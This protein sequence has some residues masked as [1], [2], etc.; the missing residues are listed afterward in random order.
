[1]KKGKIIAIVGGKGGVG[2]TTT[3]TNLAAAV[4]RKLSK[5]R[6]ATVRVGFIDN[7]PNHTAST[8]FGIFEGDLQQ[9][10]YA[11]YGARLTLGQQQT[12]VLSILHPVQ[13]PGERGGDE[14]IDLAPAHMEMSLLDM[15]LSSV[16]GRETV[17]R[18]AISGLR[19]HYDYTFIDTP[20][21]LGILSQNAMAAADWIVIPA[22]TTW[23][24]LEG[25]VQVLSVFE[26]VRA[27][28]ENSPRPQIA[29]L[30]PTFFDAREGLH[31]EVLNYLRGSAFAEQFPQLAGKVMSTHISRLSVWNKVQAQART[32]YCAY[33]D[34]ELKIAKA[35]LTRAIS[36]MDA[37]AEEVLAL[38]Q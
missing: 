33:P 32:V 25:L 28:I 11:V 4:A 3:A 34:D 2:K 19:Q 12:D 29:A 31:K 17:L 30:L 9:S 18:R 35:D 8:C 14:A 13:H 38:C 15:R 16:P 24:G 26:Q 6:N 20:P 5:A 1:M 22:Q 36:E 23:L 10:L 7:D 37:V 27:S 21:N